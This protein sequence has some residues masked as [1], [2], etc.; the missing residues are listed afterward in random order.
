M[1][2][3]KK[4]VEGLRER[5]NASSESVPALTA[6]QLEEI[7]RRLENYLRDPASAIPWQEV[8]ARLWSRLE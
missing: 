3:M 2:L 7:D 1:R 5:V 6:E 4:L 8:R